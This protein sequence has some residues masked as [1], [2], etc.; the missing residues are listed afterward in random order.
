MDLLNE[1]SNVAAIQQLLRTNPYWANYMAANSL[2][3]PRLFPLQA[4]LPIG[5]PGSNP[6]T[7][8]PNPLAPLGVPTA[9]SPTA[10]VAVSNPLPLAMF[11]FHVPTTAF[12]LNLTQGANNQPERSKTPP[13]APSDV[14]SDNK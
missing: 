5:L 3:H 10:S 6:G 13:S 7:M 4:G 14:N 9:P 11:P 12:T 2:N 1:A 8:A